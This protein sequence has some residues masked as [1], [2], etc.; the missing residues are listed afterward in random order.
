MWAG[1]VFPSCS[2]PRHA[3]PRAG[4]VTKG[5]RG[6]LE[7]EPDP[8]VIGD[9]NNAADLIQRVLELKPDVLLVDLNMPLNRQTNTS[10]SF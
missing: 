2:S 7:I 10:A 5:L 1:T 8:R 4:P 9:A 6:L 3:V